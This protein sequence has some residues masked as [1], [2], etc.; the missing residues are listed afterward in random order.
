MAQAMAKL[1]GL[2][3]VVVKNVS[4]DALVS[5]QTGGYDLALSQVTITDE[6]KEVV[7]FSDPYFNSDQGV[8]V[9][10]GH[11]GHVRDAPRT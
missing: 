4:F 10:A 11:R 5:G 3:N 2:S 9:K 8:L 7:C 1:A 6:R